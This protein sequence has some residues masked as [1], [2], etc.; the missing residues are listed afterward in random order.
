V[1]I[2]IP[3]TLA[4]M[5]AM[6]VSIGK[7]LYAL[8]LSNIVEIVRPSRDEV[9]TV[10]GQQVM[11][12]RD[13]V[14]PLVDLRTAFSARQSNGLTASS[15]SAS[16]DKR[17]LGGAFAVVAVSGDRRAGLLVDGL[18]GQQEVVI[19]P[20]D[21]LVDHTG[22]VS[23]ATVREDGG[24]SLIVDIGQLLSSVRDVA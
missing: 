19:K 24:V 16:S 3:L 4:I 1:V 6:M 20:L 8:P 15:E 14:L 5:P 7:A 2:R 22:A 9:Y 17:S 21:D 23:G 18:V 10:H 12:L 13:E 11:R